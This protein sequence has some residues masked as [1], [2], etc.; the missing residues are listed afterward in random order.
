M[1]LG[2]AREGLCGEPQEREIG[3]VEIECDEPVEDELEDRIVILALDDGIAVLAKLLNVAV[4]RLRSIGSRMV[5]AELIELGAS[6]RL[7]DEI[8]QQPE[9][10][11]ARVIGSSACHRTKTSPR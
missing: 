2:S 7:V 6:A 11:P 8:G 3:G 5:I 4:K 1:E 10:P 9:Q